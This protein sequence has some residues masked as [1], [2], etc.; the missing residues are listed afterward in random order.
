MD[1]DQYLAKKR[2]EEMRKKQ[3][4]E[5][6]PRRIREEELRRKAIEDSIRE[7]EEQAK[8]A[9]QQM[10]QARFEQSKK[11]EQLANLNTKSTVD[12][13]P[14]PVE[15]KPLI[16]D[17]KPE[18][19]VVKDI[20]AKP[21]FKDILLSASD[22]YY[23]KLRL[24]VKAIAE[25]KEYKSITEKIMVDVNPLM[26]QLL[27]ESD[28]PSVSLKINKILKEFKDNKKDDLYI[29]TL[30]FI[31]K[32]LLFKS[33]G[34]KNEDK[35]NF[36]TFAKLV[37]KIKENNE[38]ASDYFLQYIT[39]KCPYIIPKIFTKK[40]YPDSKELRKRM[41]FTNEEESLEELYGNIECYALVYFNYLMMNRNFHPIIEEFL[42]DLEVTPI[43]YP[44]ACVV[45]VYIYLCGALM[46]EKGQFKKLEDVAKKYQ[47]TLDKLKSQATSGGTKSYLSANSRFIKK[48][49][50][51]IKNNKR[52]DA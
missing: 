24:T 11:L 52:L 9:Q 15:N 49:I 6:E 46:K 35:V 3:K 14:L 33:Q 31:Y 12:N 19:A 4:E 7:K 30:D 51:N 23:R 36:F 32:R 2:D 43:E 50:T 48:Y 8:R 1:R 29:F 25:K 42:S 18:E 34:Y 5:E 45:K 16:A 38:I 10:V 39:Y 20:A 13:K 44:M 37:N 22:N 27:T 26:A 40:D 21:R 47:E 17:N 28:V 41:G